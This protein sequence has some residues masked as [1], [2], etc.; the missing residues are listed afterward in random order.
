MI[1]N[2][3][4]TYTLR[5]WTLVPWLF[6]ITLYTLGFYTAFG[7]GHFPRLSRDGAPD[8]WFCDT[9]YW[10]SY[11]L[12]LA[13]L[14]SPILQTLL[15]GLSRLGAR[16]DD[17]RLHLGVFLLGWVSVILLICFDVTGIMDWWAD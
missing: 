2:R 9:L 3:I 13:L 14:A 15:L 7:L 10:A 8:G 16:R 12:A 17:W 6:L 5:F 11:V 1:W 4:L